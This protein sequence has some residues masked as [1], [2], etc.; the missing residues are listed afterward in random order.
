MAIQSLNPA[1]NKVIKNFTPHSP[2]ELENSLN[3]ADLAFGSWR[4]TLF[5]ERADLMRRAA[6]ELKDN[7][8][9]YAE[10]IT[11]EMGKPIRESK[12]EINKCALCCEFYAEHAET[13]LKDEDIHSD[14]SVSYIS[15]E[16][17]GIILAV[18]PWNFP[19]WQVFRFAAPSLMA[20]NVGLLKHASNVP[21]C[22]LAIEEVFRKAGFP[23]GVF[24]TALVESEAVETLIKDDRIKAVTLTGSEGAG[25]SVAALAGSQIKKT[26]ME[27]GGS[28]AF[29]VLADAN[30]EETAEMAAKARMINTGQSCIAAKRFIIEEKIA[31]KFINRMKHYL[32]ALKTGDT[33]D[34]TTDYGPLARQDLAASVQKQVDESVAKGAKILLEGGRPDETSAYF[35]PMMLTDIQPGTP[36][37]EEEIFGPVACIFVVKN[38]E[39]AIKVAN[40][41]RYGLGAS[42]WSCNVQEARK[43]ARQIE[44]GAVFINGIVQSHPALPFGGIKKSGYGRELSYVGIREFVNQKTVWVA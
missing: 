22:A 10:I 19:F 39:E 44:S 36:A 7:V 9:H 31:P 30:L 42:I 6:Q 13:Y 37:H 25:A 35:H 40:E 34:E 41:S 32:Q 43:L 24:T 21:Q 15:Y 18:M 29:I 8:N 12:G 14:A 11:L 3:R 28:D 2:D 26:V 38:A 4:K 20:G 27:L 33:L 23:E 1:T 16:P 17:L 5:T